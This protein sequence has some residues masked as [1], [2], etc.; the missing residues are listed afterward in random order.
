MLLQPLSTHKDTTKLFKRPGDPF[1]IPK[2]VSGLA[3]H[4]SINI[5]Y[6]LAR[7][8]EIEYHLSLHQPHPELIQET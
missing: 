1:G 5:Q 3:I 6:M 4:Y 7:F 8:N 2:K